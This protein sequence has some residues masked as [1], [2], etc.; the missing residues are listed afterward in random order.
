MKKSF[1]HSTKASMLFNALS[2]KILFSFSKFRN[3]IKNANGYRKNKKQKKM[4]IF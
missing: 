3:G 2:Y 4:L 1:K